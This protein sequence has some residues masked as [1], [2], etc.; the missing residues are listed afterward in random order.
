MS[1]RRLG[2]DSLLPQRQK[3]PD[4]LLEVIAVFLRLGF[5]AFG[6]PA[7]HIALFRHE[8]VERRKWVSDEQFLDLLGATNLIPGPNS[9]EMAIHL[10]Y[11]RAGWPGLIAGGVC[12][13]LPAVLIVLGISW[14]YVRYQSTP[15]MGWLL[16]GVK[17]VIIAI[18]IQAL[19]MLGKKALNSPLAAIVGLGA[20]GLYF[21][22]INELALLL[23]GGLLVMLVRNRS[24]LALP[25]KNRI[26][27]LLLPTFTAGIVVGI[28]VI[29]FSL[30]VLFLTFLKI[31]AI[32]YGSGYVL[33]AFLRADFVSRLGWLT[34]QQLIDAIA[35]GQITP[36]PLFTSATFI[37]YLM[38]GMPGAVLATIGIFLPSYIFVALSNPL[39]PR[40]RNSPW[41]GALLDGVIAAS[42]GLMAAVS[43]Q[44]GQAALIDLPTTLIFLVSAVI[45]LRWRLNA[46][47]LIAAGAVFGWLISLL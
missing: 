10:G 9:T 24:R 23:A 1:S 37:G 16:Y 32:L 11:V 41:A 7:A 4:R 40:I 19:W 46:T 47:W 30:A 8:V 14:L 12:F 31:G 29:P 39:I 28:S 42:L 20:A 26:P 35:I 44:L 43:L 6:G 17:P 22:G 21:L 15:Q 34:E 36:G 13:T 25:G 3:K 33:V 38:G 45:L 2:N 18:I 5:T 27:A